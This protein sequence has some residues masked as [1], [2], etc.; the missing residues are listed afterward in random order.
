M[1]PFI[2]PPNRLAVVSA[3]LLLAALACSGGAASE[4]EQALVGQW[5]RDDGQE[6]IEFSTNR[7]VTIEIL[8]ATMEGEFAVIDADTLQMDIAILDETVTSVYAMTLSQDSLTLT[9][10][11]GASATYKR[12]R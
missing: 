4:T 5:Q 2:S 7:N 10:E 3:L 9:A 11:D 6:T 1:L 12:V 8:G